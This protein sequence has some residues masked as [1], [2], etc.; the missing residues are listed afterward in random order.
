MRFSTAHLRSF[1]EDPGSDKHQVE[2]VLLLYRTQ[3]LPTVSV[4]TVQTMRRAMRTCQYC[5]HRATGR[6]VAQVNFHNDMTESPSSCAR[7]RVAGWKRV[8]LGT[9]RHPLSPGSVGNRCTTWREPTKPI[10]CRVIFRNQ[11]TNPNRTN[12]MS[13]ADVLGFAWFC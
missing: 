5:G 12:S 9:W 3:Y 1:R 2:L 7:K 4:T 8:G 10:G 6:G 13:S 11:T